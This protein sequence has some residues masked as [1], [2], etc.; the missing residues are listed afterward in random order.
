MFYL[1]EKYSP[2]RKKNKT[3]QYTHETGEANKDRV[4]FWIPQL[5]G[6]LSNLDNIYGFICSSDRISFFFLTERAN[7]IHCNAVRQI[8]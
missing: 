3:K 6:R 2:G 7:Q 5:Q 4:C 8:V 1:N